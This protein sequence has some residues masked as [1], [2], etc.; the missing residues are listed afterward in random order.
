MVQGKHR[1]H[2]LQEVTK[3]DVFFSG[4]KCFYS[5]KSIIN[6]LK[7]QIMS[8]LFSR[9]TPPENNHIAT[10]EKERS[11]TRKVPDG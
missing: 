9:I 3:I 10:W 11:S 2:G 7:C 8:N 4:K 6:T 5:G 1:N